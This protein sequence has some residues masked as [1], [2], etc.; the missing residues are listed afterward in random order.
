MSYDGSE[1][2]ITDDD[3]LADETDRRNKSIHIDPLSTD[4]IEARMDMLASGDR[5]E[6]FLV[7]L[8]RRMIIGATYRARRVWAKREYNIDASTVDKIEALIRH[9][10]RMHTL[11]FNDIFTRKEDLR[12]KY[13]A[14]FYEQMEA[15]DYKNAGKTLDSL[16]KLEGLVGPDIHNN[17]NVS[18][19]HRESITSA[20]RERV[21]QLFTKMRDLAVPSQKRGIATQLLPEVNK[22]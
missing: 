5:R 18:V 7:E 8:E 13:L 21:Q 10:W 6:E 3:I 1:P 2:V 22:K 4:E 19:Q 17:V 11:D 15:C 14:L 9:G 16:A 20:T 12:Q